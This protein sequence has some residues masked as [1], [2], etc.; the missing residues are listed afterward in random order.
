MVL[1]HFYRYEVKN[2]TNCLK[3]SKQANYF[4]VVYVERTYLQ[5][6]SFSF[7]VQFRIS[8]LFAYIVTSTQ[9]L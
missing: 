4:F 8:Y 1:L 7:L 3:C 5:Q 6:D 2:R 9:N